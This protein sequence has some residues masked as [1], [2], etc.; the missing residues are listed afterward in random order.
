MLKGRVMDL[1][2]LLVIAMV[3]LFI[4][5]VTFGILNSQAE[6]EIQQYS[7]S[8][9]IAGALVSVS[10]LASVY[11][12]LRKSSGELE[13]L[14][15][16]N[17]E[18]EH[19]LIR[20]APHP[21]QFVIEVDERQRIVLARPAE[22]K[23]FGGVIFDFWRPPEGLPR[24]KEKLT[25]PIPMPPELSQRY[26]VRFNAT[27][28]PI[29]SGVSEDKYY[30]RYLESVK[31]NPWI[32]EMTAE[33]VHL[34]GEGGKTRSLKLIGQTFTSL[35]IGQDP[36]TLEPM[37]ITSP[38][39]AQQVKELR[40]RPA[41]PPSP[42]AAANASQAPDSPASSPAS[43]PSAPQPPQIAQGWQ[44]NVVCY[45]K[46]LGKVFFF[47]FWDDD[48]DFTESSSQFNKILDSIRFLT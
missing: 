37:L 39:T 22:W 43:A 46:Q 16:K 3:G 29:P 10:L 21:Q 23:P 28:I 25:S 32:G 33:Y 35:M 9:A 38:F 1:I 24:L 34:G 18:L 7:V 48:H 14:R 45:H 26:P 36:I 19:K 12:Q 40:E 11:L 13:E 15:E 47:S 30:E 4:A 27:F 2:V 5:Y 41:R 31:S 6:A 20:G 17:K 44:M 42:Q 8:G